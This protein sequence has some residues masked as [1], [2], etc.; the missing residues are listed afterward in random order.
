[1]ATLTFFLNALVITFSLLILMIKHT[2]SLSD[3]NSI[4]RVAEFTDA[5]IAVYRD[6]R[7]HLHVHIRIAMGIRS[8]I[9]SKRPLANDRE[10][11]TAL[12]G[13]LP[14]DDTYPRAS[15]R[16]HASTRA[17]NDIYRRRSG[18]I[19]YPPMGIISPVRDTLGEKSRL[20][21][22]LVTS[23]SRGSLLVV[24]SRRTRE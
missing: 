8:A 15:T 9:I 11:H 7:Y 6:T 4:Y 18:T 19:N 23:R 10:L 13:F 16:T 12:R 20:P 1:M 2:R 22:G 3:A 24:E 17:R 5:A 21:A 14:L